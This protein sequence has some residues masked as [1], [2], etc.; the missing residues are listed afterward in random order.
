MTSTASTSAENQ[1]GSS[2][3]TGT[4]LLWLLRHQLSIIEVRS[5]KIARFICKVIPP[6]CPF[7]RDIQLLGQTLV[8][9][10]AL[11]KLNPFYDQL[12]ELRFQAL[13]YLADE[14]GEDV[15]VY[16]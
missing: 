2:N 6:C 12:V 14:C 7:E 1:A 5:L 10:P 8:H 4:Y 3:K 15:T 11:C 9:I 13:T 16:C